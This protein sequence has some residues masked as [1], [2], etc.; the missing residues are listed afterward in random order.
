MNKILEI[1]FGSALYG[2]STPNSDLDLKGIYLPTAK[3]ICLNSYKRT[4][5]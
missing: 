2:T 3:E 5:S 1:K 4:T